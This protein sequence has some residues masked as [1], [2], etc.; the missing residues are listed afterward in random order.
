MCVSNNADQ[1]KFLVETVI[2]NRIYESQYW[3]EHCFALTGNHLLFFLAPFVLTRFTA[4][5]VIDKA[6]ATRCIGGVYGN[7]RPTQFLCLLLKL[8]Q[9]Q[10]EKE[11]L[12][13]YLRADEF[14]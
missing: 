4:E 8:L 10:P 13:E 3:K 9:I 12:V 11:I 14:K 2:R 1:I 5:S 6:I 7:Q